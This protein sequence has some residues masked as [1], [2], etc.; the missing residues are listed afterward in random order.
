MSALVT[1]TFAD[2]PELEAAMWAMPDTW[3]VF[4][5]HDEIAAALFLH[6]P[7]TSP[8]LCLVATE[9][10][11]VWPGRSAAPFALHT[12]RR[13]TLPAGGWVAC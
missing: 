5:G 11:E 3:P 12:A 8:H 4:M 6:V 1:T 2:R 10:E 13:G 7:S 9:G